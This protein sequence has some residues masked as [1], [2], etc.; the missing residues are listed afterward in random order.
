MLSVNAIVYYF[1]ES[2]GGKVAKKLLGDTLGYL[3]IDGYSGYN[4]IC[5]EENGGRIRVGCWSHLRRLFFEALGELSEN[6]TVLE[7]IVEL[8]RIEYKAAELDILGTID[9]LALRQKYAVPIMDKIYDWIMEKKKIMPPKGDTGKAITYAINQW[10]SLCVYLTDACIR[11]DNNLSENALRIIALGRKN[12]LFVGHE[13]AGQNLAIL[14]TITSTC[15]LHNVDAYEY[16]KDVIIRIQTHPASKIDEL[17]PQNWKPTT[18][19]SD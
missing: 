5:D 11:L 8:Y 19:D 14:Q 9:H 18:L 12:F 3:Q 16:I 10:E 7:W 2:R 6:R 17:L 15:R 1:S 13:V 4:T